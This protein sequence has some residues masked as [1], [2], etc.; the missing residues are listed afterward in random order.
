MPTWSSDQLLVRKQHRGFTL[1]ELMMVLLLI[2]LLVGAGLTLDYASS[3]SSQQQQAGLLAQQFKLATL[4]AVQSGNMWALDFFRVP[5]AGGTQAGYRWLFHDG[6]RWRE[7]D[8]AIVDASSSA[9]LLPLAMQL[10]LSVDGAALEPELQQPLTTASNAAN[11]RFAPE[12]LLLPTHEITAFSAQL[13]SSDHN[14]C[15]V[16]VTVDALGR[17]LVQA[18]HETR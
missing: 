7:A 8:P 11:T 6:S 17:V 15:N 16:S 4:E 12:I 10:R 9:N 18:D 5:V 13:C 3:P 14:Q 2:G 1:L